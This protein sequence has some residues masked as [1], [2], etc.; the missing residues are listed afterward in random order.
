[1][2]V[3]FP[4]ESLTLPMT[5]AMGPGELLGM[6]SGSTFFGKTILLVLLVMSVMSWA[7]FIDKARTLNRIR[8]GHQDF[9]R[10]CD[11]WLDRRI[12][13]PE[14]VIWTREHA[15]LPLSTVVLETAEL[16]EVPAI[17]R[18]AERVAYLETENLE[19]YIILLSTAVTIS[20]FLGLLGTVWGI[21]TSFWDMSTMHS[22]NLTVVAPGIAEALVT[23][24]AG[25]ATAIPAVIFYNTLVRKI[26]LV[27]NEMDR[28]RTILE[29]EAGG[30]R[31]VADPVDRDFARRPEQHDGERI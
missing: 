1:M 15:D 21:M 31:G 18:A 16:Q 30:G 27:G 22:A 5:A 28:L 2:S 17:R 25:L 4:P 19:R 29:E 11:Q 10:Q 23:T 3:L 12:T 26:D 24:V 8:V 13:S 7:V 6:V 14:L 20:P 9:W